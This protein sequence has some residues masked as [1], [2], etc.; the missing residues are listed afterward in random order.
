MNLWNQVNIECG[1]F[2]KKQIIGLQGSK[3]YH[4]CQAGVRMHRIPD[5]EKSYKS[6]HRNKPYAED[7][8]P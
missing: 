1:F 2:S 7:E 8:L 4:K 5:V 3:D 6:I